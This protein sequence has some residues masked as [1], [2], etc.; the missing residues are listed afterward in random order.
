HKNCH[1]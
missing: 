1:Q